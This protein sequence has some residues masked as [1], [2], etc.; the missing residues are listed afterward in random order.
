MSELGK[1]IDGTQKKDAIHVAIYPVLATEDLLQG[2]A[3]KMVYGGTYQVKAADDDKGIGIVDP[4]LSDP[5]RQGQ[6]FYMV[7]Y[8]NTVTGLRHDW[9][10]PAIA[11][12]RNDED[13]DY[14][15]GCRGC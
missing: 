1:L 5:V 12:E 15:D 14:D 4:F 7:L 10:H 2:Q 8:P 3:I 6:W 13:Y 9:D 11:H